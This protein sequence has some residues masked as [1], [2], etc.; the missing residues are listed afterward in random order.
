MPSIYRNKFNRKPRQE[1]RTPNTARDLG[2]KFDA[3]QK[4]HA[5]KAAEPKQTS[6]KEDVGI[7]AKLAFKSGGSFINQ[8][9]DANAKVGN[10]IEH[11]LYRHSRQGEIDDMLI[12][13]MQLQKKLKSTASKRKTT[14][15]EVFY[16]IK[17][18]N[19]KETIVS[20]RD[21]KRP[22]SRRR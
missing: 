7:L 11:D 5:A 1:K 21:F 22:A 9:M 13:Q 17:D 12:K 8:V 10:S 16:K 15:A 14:K 18:I 19:G 2:K 4:A 20:E 6:W 3:E